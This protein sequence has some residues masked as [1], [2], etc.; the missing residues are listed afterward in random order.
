LQNEVEFWQKVENRPDHTDSPQLLNYPINQFKNIINAL[1]ASKDPQN[2]DYHQH[3]KNWFEQFETNWIYSANLAT[4]PWLDAHKISQQTAAAFLDFLRNNNLSN[5]SNAQ[6][7]NGYLL[8]YEFKNQD[9]SKIL[10]RRVA[11]GESF[12]QIRT[13][14][15]KSKDSLISD[16]SEFKKDFLSWKQSQ[17]E[18]FNTHKN[19]KLEE[20]KKETDQS[21]ERIN[22]LEVLF[23][24]KLRLEKPAQHWA[25][26]ATA[27]K[28][29][30]NKWVIGL[31]VTLVLGF[32]FFG[33]LFGVWL[34]GTDLPLTIH[35]FQGAVLLTV[36]IS[37]FVF[38]IRFTS[39]IA[40]SSYHLQ[41]DAEEKEQLAHVFLS[42]INEKKDAIDAEAKKIVFQALF[43][44]AESGLLGVD[45]S[46]TMPMGDIISTIAKSGKG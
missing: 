14:L 7:F 41:R 1:E 6:Y 33:F 22:E 39:K 3:I 11:E 27:L 24:E 28:K 10:S 21:F 19:L 16:V 17:F 40:L 46:P 30:G 8:A 4:R 45:S 35:T 44:R 37:M 31:V 38:A 26:R 2:A 43:S 20:L 13:V 23:N 9:E 25:N 34:N 5:Y 12:E 29:Q 32:I 15:L 36:L 42:L 18:D